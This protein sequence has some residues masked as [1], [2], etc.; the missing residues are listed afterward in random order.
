MFKKLEGFSTGL[1]YDR[2]P[3]RAVALAYSARA[4]DI[5][6]PRN[7]NPDTS[8]RRSFYRSSFH[9]SNLSHT[10]PQIRS[11]AVHVQSHIRHCSRSRHSSNITACRRLQPCAPH[12]PPHSH[13]NKILRSGHDFPARRF[14]LPIA[15]RARL[16]DLT[17]RNIDPEPRTHVRPAKL[18]IHLDLARVVDFGHRQSIRISVQ[19]AASVEGLCFDKIWQL[20]CGASA[21]VVFSA[22]L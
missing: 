18:Q 5:I 7:Q 17:Q 19:V 11:E 4:G 13:E 8:S 22:A 2:K 6:L 3:S 9:R 12:C 16:H 15:K 1:R 20:R 21:V 14:V 10:S